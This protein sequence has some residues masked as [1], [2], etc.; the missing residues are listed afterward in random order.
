MDDTPSLRVQTA[1]FGRCWYIPTLYIQSWL[2]L[3]GDD[4][5]IEFQI[6]TQKT[7]TLPKTKIA[8]ENRPSQKEN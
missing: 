6:Q 1:A 4:T 2:I 3:G 8:P 5:L 7:D